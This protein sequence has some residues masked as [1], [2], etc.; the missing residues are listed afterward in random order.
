M[1]LQKFGCTECA[2]QKEPPRLPNSSTAEKL[3]LVPATDGTLSEFRR[4]VCIGV[5][6]VGHP[7]ASNHLRRR[8]MP[9]PATIASITVVPGS[10]DCGF[11]FQNCK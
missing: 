2:D 1:G 11:R 7:E 9:N 8:M 6:A 3:Q 4:I 5:S 10:G